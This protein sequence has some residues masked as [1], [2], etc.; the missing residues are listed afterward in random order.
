MAFIYKEKIVFTSI[1]NHERTEKT[2]VLFHVSEDMC[3]SIPLFTILIYPGLCLL[4]DAP[5]NPSLL[6]HHHKSWAHG[7]MRAM[8]HSGDATQGAMHRR[9]NNDPPRF[10]EIRPTT[11]G[12]VW[13]SRH[14]LQTGRGWGVATPLPGSGPVLLLSGT[15]RRCR[16]VRGST[17]GCHRVMGRRG[18]WRAGAW[19]RAERDARTSP[20]LASRPGPASGARLEPHGSSTAVR[21]ER[22]VP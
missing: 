18:P 3:T 21:T 2:T 16:G 4:C 20:T 17:R 7:D 19:C 6:L 9:K 12:V 1:T 11:S 15:L 14:Q 8:G 13:G 5:T 22:T 10:H